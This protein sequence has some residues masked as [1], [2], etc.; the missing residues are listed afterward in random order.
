MAGVSVPSG[1]AASSLVFHVRGPAIWSAEVPRPNVHG[2][3]SEQAMGQRSHSPSEFAPYLDCSKR[4]LRLG[5]VHFTG[6][7][8]RFAHC[9][10]ERSHEFCDL[11]AGEFDPD[12]LKPV[13]LK[14]LR[15][16]L[17]YFE[18]T[19]RWLLYLENALQNRSRKHPVLLTKPARMQQP[20]KDSSPPPRPRARGKKAPRGKRQAPA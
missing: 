3:T 1:R 5:G 6:F 13:T 9:C 2:R 17:A 8:G 7:F 18:G 19:R 11:L 10:Q 4:L 14:L 20:P 12:M 15:E 16:Q